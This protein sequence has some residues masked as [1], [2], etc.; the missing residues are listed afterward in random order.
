M[1]GAQVITG[2]D[3]V[4]RAKNQA[5]PVLSAIEAQIKVLNAETRGWRGGLDRANAGLGQINLAAD[6]AAKRWGNL[7]TAAHGAG[8]AMA[9][10]GGA[11][12]AG[13]AAAIFKTAE[14]GD[15]LHD[16]SL[17]SNIAVKDLS[18]LGYM[19]Q[20]TGADLTDIS[21]AAVFMQKGVT[22]GGDAIAKLQE[23][24]G[25]LPDMEGDLSGVGKAVTELGIKT[26]DAGGK[27][28]PTEQIF[29]RT[30]D[31]LR[32]M[33]DPQRRLLYAIQLFGR[34]GQTLLPILNMDRAAYNALKKDAEDVAWSKA[35]ADAAHDWTEAMTKLKAVLGTT[36]RDAVIPLIKELQPLIPEIEGL[37]LN[38]G[39]FAAAHPGWVKMSLE[40]G[41]FALALGPALMALEKIIR[42]VTLVRAGILAMSSARGLSAILGGGGGAATA[43]A[44]NAGRAARDI[45][46]DIAASQVASRAA[47]R[48]R[49][50]LPMGA[51]T[52]QW[53]MQ[54]AYG[55]GGGLENILAARR[56]D[57][58]EMGEATGEAV[59]KS[60]SAGLRAS[61]PGV[62]S[63]IATALGSSSVW[64][65]V[66]LAV[67][68]GIAAGWYLVTQAQAEADKSAAGAAK[69]QGKLATGGT[70]I[71]DSTPGIN[72]EPDILI[73][74]AMA[75]DKG[76][77]QGANP[78]TGEVGW[79]V[80]AGEM[81][82][83]EALGHMTEQYKSRWRLRPH[84][85]NPIPYREESMAPPAS[86]A[87]AK[88]RAALL[89]ANA[90]PITATPPTPPAGTTGTTGTAGAAGPLPDEKRKEIDDYFKALQQYI[91]IAEIA[92]D[93]DAVTR[94]QDALVAGYNKYADALTA[95]SAKETNEAAKRAD[96][97]AA[98][99]NRV[100]AMRLDAERRKQ[101]EEEAK[102]TTEK[103]KA[104]WE[105][106]LKR[107]GFGVDLAKTQG[108][109]ALPQAQEALAR[110]H[111]Q[112]S[113]A[114]GGAGTTEGLGEYAQYATL[115]AEANKW[116]GSPESY[117]A[118]G[119]ATGRR[120]AGG[121][122]GGINVKEGDVR[123]NVDVTLD[124]EKLDAR[125]DRRIEKTTAGA[126]Y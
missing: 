45:Y 122:E 98:T 108:G 75:R 113:A 14:Y 28:L 11:V 56:R 60:A 34:G 71:P 59:V 106:Y 87:E 102:K 30:V 119:P 95:S 31:A 48:A 126:R 8:L 40:A 69:A 19:A 29:W 23:K 18:E 6:A 16:L 12:V 20:V 77:T 120:G 68:A 115:H 54:A 10:A 38:A 37:V 9:V 103:N 52:P 63:Q 50:L 25:G 99:D 89:I 73:N 49:D 118:Q 26:K 53:S 64:G 17:R 1:S 44:A 82:E 109:T 27:F 58:V 94:G 35:Q 3:V 22:L 15:H 125:V 101:A 47:A 124:G 21:R 74:R 2:L 66:G 110:G 86:S 24:A 105:D 42:T 33:E 55:T 84:S 36:T 39:K 100:A 46:A 13:F 93:R 114:L 97:L 65:A 32:A 79:T 4:I 121:A 61:A 117:R 78:R 83:A 96:L 62:G 41:L 92:G 67:A 90:T 123:V 107:L 104:G 81:P 80:P 7:T 85:F 57:F 43:T 5:S 88:Q 116:W 76:W 72:G 111:Y 51:G 112:Y 91:D 70:W